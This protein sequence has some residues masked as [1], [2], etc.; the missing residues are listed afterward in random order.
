MNSERPF[1][2]L[3][4]SL[5]RDTLAFFN[6]LDLCHLL[7]V[8]HRFNRLIE[9]EFSTKPYLLLHWLYYADGRWRWIQTVGPPLPLPKDV[10]AQLPTSKFVRFEFV[11]VER[12]L[13]S[14]SLFSQIDFSSFY[15]F[16]V[17]VLWTVITRM[18]A[19]MLPTP[20]T[21]GSFETK[22][23]LPISHVWES[24]W[25]RINMDSDIVPTVEFARAISKARDIWLCCN[26]ILGLLDKLLA[27]NCYSAIIGDL[28]ANLVAM[29]WAEIVG[30]LFERS[31]KRIMIFTPR[32]PN[33]AQLARFNLFLDEVK[34]RFHAADMP[35]TFYFVWVVG[36]EWRLQG[37]DYRGHNPLV[38]LKNVGLAQERWTGQEGWIGSAARTLDCLKNAGW[39]LKMLP[40]K[41]ESAKA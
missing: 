32:P 3:S 37:S 22:V 4:L 10:L 25:L 39:M 26:G 35:V 9:K 27:G 18:L 2:R 38:C 40:G 31:F 19:F 23:M 12:D 16:V 14:K 6:R 24:Q 13:S 17:S 29:P 41:G 28:S 7:T 33:G 1:T 30:H 15:Q 21:L 36:E 8:N 11:R 34:M 20:E 5:L